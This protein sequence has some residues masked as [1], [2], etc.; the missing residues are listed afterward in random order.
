MAIAYDTGTTPQFSTGSSI[1]FSHTCTGSNLALVVQ[2][3]ARDSTKSNTPV[4]GVTYSG[5]A[6]TKA[7]EDTETSSNQMTQSLWVKG[8][9]ATGANNVVISFTGSVAT[10]CGGSA[11][12][13]TDTDS[14]PDGANNG[15]GSSVNTNSVTLSLTTTADNSWIVGA[16][17]TGGGSA[18]TFTIDSGDTQRT[19]ASGG[20]TDDSMIM[21]TTGPITPSG[22]STQMGWSWDGSASQYI[23]TM[24]EIKVNAGAGAIPIQ[25]NFPRALLAR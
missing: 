25:T 10:W 7:R 5:V 2:G 24:V 15:V 23:F 11:V 1:T 21:S 12:S 6:L 19:K 4:T 16:L 18:V 3:A 14:S 22:T 17:A 9:P 20:S 13:L 8:S